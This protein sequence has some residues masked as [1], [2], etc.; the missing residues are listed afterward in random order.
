MK[1]LIMK[2]PLSSCLFYFTLGAIPT[3]QEIKGKSKSKSSEGKA[4]LV[5]F[6]N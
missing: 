1:L 6:F 4:V 3:V 2:F 5:L